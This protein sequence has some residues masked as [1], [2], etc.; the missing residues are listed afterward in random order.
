MAGNHRNTCEPG[1]D[2]IGRCKRTRVAPFG[3]AVNVAWFP[4][5]VTKYRT[6]R[7]ALSKK[8]IDAMTQVTINAC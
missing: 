8:A 2:L 7:I 4:M 3:R 1:A 6:K 5:E